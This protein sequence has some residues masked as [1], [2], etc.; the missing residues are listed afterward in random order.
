M[1]ALSP[2][3]LATTSAEDDQRRRS[4]LPLPW[5]G[6]RPH[7]VPPRLPPTLAAVLATV[8][9]EGGQDGGRGGGSTTRTLL[10]SSWSS[11]PLAVA[12]GLR[13]LSSPPR[14]HRPSSSSPPSS[15]PS[16]DAADHGLS[17]GVEHPPPLDHP[18]MMIFAHLPDFG[19]LAAR[20]PAAAGRSFFQITAHP[21]P[22][23]VTKAPCRRR[24]RRRCCPLWVF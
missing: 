17:H 11:P 2:V 14:H 10:W 19:V 6:S 9:A 4:S 18:F 3:P 12:A 24:R 16:H 22:R 7:T 8:V 5:G 15:S 13:S 21:P 23:A 20:F 1:R